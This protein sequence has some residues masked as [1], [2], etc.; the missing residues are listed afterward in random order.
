VGKP[1]SA[2]RPSRCFGNT[3]TYDEKPK[4]RLCE[5]SHSQGMRVNQ[6]VMFFSDGGADIREVQA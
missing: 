4:R 2:D 6:R 3:P 5:V 1:M